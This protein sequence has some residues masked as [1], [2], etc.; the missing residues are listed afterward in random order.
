[1][2]EKFF[3][4]QRVVVEDI[5]LFIRADVHSNGV[6]LAVLYRAVRILEVDSTG[7]DALDLGTTKRYAGLVIVVHKIIVS[8]FS[9][10]SYNHN[11]LFGRHDGSLLSKYVLHD[12]P[13]HGNYNI[14][15]AKN[16]AVAG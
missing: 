11:A 8:G 10:L 15:F 2:H 4:A 16:Q 14:E 1:M 13:R 7:P 3:V 6:E 5:S 12:T 9:V